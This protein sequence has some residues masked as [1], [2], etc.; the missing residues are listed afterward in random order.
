MY[1]PGR[2]IGTF[3]FGAFEE[4]LEA[5]IGA[6]LSKSTFRGSVVLSEVLLM[7]SEAKRLK[8]SSGLTGCFEEVCDLRE[9]NS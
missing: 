7:L 3:G 2:M 5:R 1:G 6:N 4:G 8:V 9:P